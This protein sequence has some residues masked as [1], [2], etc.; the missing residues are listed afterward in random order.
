[1]TKDASWYVAAQNNDQE[2]RVPD[3][4]ID[5]SKNYCY[6]KM[7][8]RELEQRHKDSN[9][10]AR[11][12]FRNFSLE[13]LVLHESIIEISL[14]YQTPDEKLF[15][16][17]CTELQANANLAAYKDNLAENIQSSKQ[18]SSQQI[19]KF[20]NN[21]DG[22]LI[23]KG[24]HE[25]LDAAYP[26]LSD[27]KKLDI[28]QNSLYDK[29]LSTKNEILAQEIVKNAVISTSFTEYAQKALK[30]TSHSEETRQSVLVVGGAASGKGSITILAK[31]SL[32]DDTVELNPDL[33]KKLILPE[34]KIDYT[35]YDKRDTKIQHGSIT[36]TESSIIFDKIADRWSQMA[37]SG[38]APNL[39]MDVCR[40]GNWM[41]D[42]ASSGNTKINVM[43]ANVSTSSA[44]DRAWQR[45]EAT[46]RFM[47]TKDLLQGHADQ[48]YT[49]SNA[50]TNRSC[51]ILVFS[52]E[53][54]YGH[55]PTLAMFTDQESKSLN[56]VDHKAVVHYLH[57]ASINPQA[58]SEENLHNLRSSTYLIDTIKNIT[59]NQHDSSKTLSVNFFDD[60]GELFA[61]L[62]NDKIQIHASN[63]QNFSE[64]LQSNKHLNRIMESAI[65]KNITF[66]HENKSL[67][68][69]INNT[70][71]LKKSMTL[72]PV[73]EK[74]D[75][76][77]M[78]VQKKGMQL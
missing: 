54:V 4:T 71:E 67:E 66:I 62:Q 28:M 24:W 74:N 69:L 77:R 55:V 29:I 37:K 40:A 16:G 43:A 23:L 15:Q 50:I 75:N 18:E 41:I 48:I 21:P 35:L 47:P 6:E 3:K 46:G 33:Y 64:T 9:I 38:R 7:T 65:A 61:T 70:I 1:M 31:K 58:T 76:I 73:N 12:E 2:S 27:N 68:T 56:I 59:T 72:L 19:E 36:H 13:K 52:T 60:K 22:D 45:G 78:P 42:I 5:D 57:K 39:L 44:L 30:L 17:M 10:M 34:H 11:N 25:K 49:Q 32:K 8:N 20:R 26:E 51:N 53:T 63:F 14:N